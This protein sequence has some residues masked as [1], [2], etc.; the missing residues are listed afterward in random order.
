MFVRMSHHLIRRCQQ[1]DE[2]IYPSLNNYN[3]LHKKSQQEMLLGQALRMSFLRLT[4][5]AYIT[6]S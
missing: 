1:R 5:E 6:D 4:T 2:S 3:L